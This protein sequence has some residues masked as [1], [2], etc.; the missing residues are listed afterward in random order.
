MFVKFFNETKNVLL[1]GAHLFRNSSLKCSRT[2]FK[3]FAM[4]YSQ[5]MKIL[6][7]IVKTIFTH[8]LLQ[9]HTDNQM[10]QNLPY[11]CVYRASFDYHLPTFVLLSFCFIMIFFKM[12]RVLIKSYS[13]PDLPIL[14]P[15]AVLTNKFPLK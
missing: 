1:T 2:D 3:D 11:M 9:A 13:V 6:S 4:K 14:L 15:Y 5:T 8:F 7:F 12:D 10:G